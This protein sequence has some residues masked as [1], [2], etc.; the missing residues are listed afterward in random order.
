MDRRQLIQLVA[1][2]VAGSSVI[3]TGRHP[4]AFGESQLE[5]SEP[6]AKLPEGAVVLFQGDSITDAHRDKKK[7][8]SRANDARALG[9]GYP[10]VIAGQLLREYPTKKLKFFNRGISGNKVP[11]LQKRWQEDCIDLKPDLLSILVGVNDMWHKMNGRYDGTVEDYRQGFTE[12]LKR[13]RDELPEV[14][15]VI[16]EPFALR[17]GAVKDSWFPEFDER[18]QVAAE[19]ANAAEAVWVPFQKMFE[20]AMAAGTEAKVWA[21]DGVHPTLAGHALM[22]ETW[23]RCVNVS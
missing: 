5:D 18:R 6:G 9:D 23:R 1:G 14:Q 11:N 19:V 3:G 2:T 12:L 4:A 10:F 17:C 8:A 13:T 15:L 20:T 7:F 21:A 16:C 22:A